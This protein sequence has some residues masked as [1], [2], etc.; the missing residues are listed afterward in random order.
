M[1]RRPKRATVSAEEMSP[2][3]PTY[4]PAKFTLFPRVPKD[5]FLTDTRTAHSDS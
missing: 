1:V 2:M 5:P 4:Q 3:S